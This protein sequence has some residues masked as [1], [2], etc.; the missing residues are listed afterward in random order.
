MPKKTTKPKPQ[1]FPHDGLVNI[2]QALKFMNIGR[3][4]FYSL[5]KKGSVQPPVKLGSAVR[6]PAK[7]IREVAGVA[8]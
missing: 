4:H 8:A 1:P 7:H 2:A 3:T 5:I 6:W